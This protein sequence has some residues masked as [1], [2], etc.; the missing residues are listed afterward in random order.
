MRDI[1]HQRVNAAI[2]HECLETGDGALVIL[3]L[4]QGAG[5]AKSRQGCIATG[6]VSGDRIE[7]FKPSLRVLFNQR[8]GIQ[9]IV[10]GRCR[11]RGRIG[12]VASPG[13]H[14]EH[15]NN[16]TANDVFAEAV[17]HPLGAV[18]ADVFFDFTENI[19]HEVGVGPSNR[20]AARNVRRTIMFKAQHCNLAGQTAERSVATWLRF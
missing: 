18:L 19:G 8:D 7:S 13:G 4:R 5:S 17:P 9:E 12:I 1:A 20:R 2:I 15:Q 14:A 6:A 3:V 10:T 11:L 16:G